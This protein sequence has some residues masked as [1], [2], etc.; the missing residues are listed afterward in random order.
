MI[1]S[2]P[3]SRLARY[4]YGSRDICGSL[5]HHRSIPPPLNLM[6]LVKSSKSINDC[7][8]VKPSARMVVRRRGRAT[9]R[10][11]PHIAYDNPLEQVS[12]AGAP[13]H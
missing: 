4:L 10:T 7:P 8:A 12:R 11:V 13:S 1:T 5:M 3:H 6:A 9:C 2:K